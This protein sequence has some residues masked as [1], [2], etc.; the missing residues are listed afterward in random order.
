MEIKTKLIIQNNGL[1]M[2]FSICFSKS[3]L[4][5]IEEFVKMNVRIEKIGYIEQ[6]N[7]ISEYVLEYLNDEFELKK[8]E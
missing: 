8:G 7:Y 5:K 1:G 4:E 6:N 3:I 2:N